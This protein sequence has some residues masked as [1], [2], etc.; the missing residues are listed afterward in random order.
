MGEV[1]KLADLVVELDIPKDKGE[2]PHFKALHAINGLLYA[3][4]NTFEKQDFEGKAMHGRSYAGGGRLASWNGKNDSKW[5]ILERTAFVEVT[6]RRNFGVVTY[7]VGWDSQSAILKVLDPQ[8]GKWQTFRLPKASHAYD[9]LWQTE[10]PRIREVETERYL[11]DA[12]GMFY[13][14]SP[15]GWGGATWGVRPISQHLRVVP[16]FASFR[17]LLVLGGNQVS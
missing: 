7:A 8:V 14:L 5:E 2:Q 4:S 10:W 6:G 16:D 1:T 15:L 9:H 3:A 17:G 13:E 12:H 11:M